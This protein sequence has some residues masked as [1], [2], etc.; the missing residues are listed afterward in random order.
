M[1]WLSLGD[2][3][4][5]LEYS[6]IC[7]LFPPRLRDGFR[8]LFCLGCV[9]NEGE[10][11]ASIQCVPDTGSLISCYRSIKR[12]VEKV[13]IMVLLL[14]VT[15]VMVMILVMVR[16]VMMMILVMVR[17]VISHQKHLISSS[18]FEIRSHYAALVDLKLA[19]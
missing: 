16:M 4:A 3:Y 10:K 18:F 8:A 11:V 2:Y 1:P 5:L 13:M 15:M 12:A 14:L 6:E 19:M 9:T 7:F 17:M